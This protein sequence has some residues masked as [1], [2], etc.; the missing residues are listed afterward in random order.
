MNQ[1]REEMQQQVIKSQMIFG[2]IAAVSLF[3]AAI[4]IINTM[5]MAIYE[6]TREIG[7]MKVL[8][9]E[10]GS[11]RTMFLLESSTIGFIGGLIGVAFSLLASFVLNNLSTILAA[12]GQGGGLDLS[13]LMGGG[14]YYMDGGRQRGHF[15]H[16]ALAHAGGVG[17]RHAGGAG[18]RY[19]ARKQGS[20][21]QR[22][23]SHPA[24]LSAICLYKEP[25]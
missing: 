11:I 6:R 16:P 12:F 9:C 15:D 14:Y 2:G 7:V 23:G 25:R 4:N 19:P 8:G 1:Q 5:T 18:S 13:G 17:I 21:D 10:L 24:R 20:Q 3:V 22:T